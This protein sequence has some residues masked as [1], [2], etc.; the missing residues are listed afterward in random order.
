MVGFLEET[1]KTLQAT[2]NISRE[3]PL[4]SVNYS[5]FVPD[6]GSELYTKIFGEQLKKPCYELS[7]YTDDVDSKRFAPKYLSSQEIVTIQKKAFYAFFLRWKQIFRIIKAIESFEDI[8]RY[9][10]MVF[11]AVI[12]ITRILTRKLKTFG[13]VIHRKKHNI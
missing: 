6:P 3:L 11:G 13:S 12:L 2:L 8:R 10:L 5:V 7:T 4:Y 9:S 1:H